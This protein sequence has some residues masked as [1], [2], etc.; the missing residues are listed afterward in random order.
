LADL[1]VFPHCDMH[2]ALH[3]APN[4]RIRVF[5]RSPAA[6]N[7]TYT[8]TDVTSQCTF[9]FFAPYNAVGSRLQAFVAIDP[10]TGAVTANAV[11]INLIQIRLN[12]QYIVARI[13][14]HDTILGWWFGNGSITT[15]LD[16]R[17]AHAQPSIYALFSDDGAVGTD[18]VGDISGHGYVALTSGNPAVFTVDGNGRLQ[19]VSETDPHQP[20]PKLTG[21]FLA[22]D[23]TIDVRVVDYGKAR[24]I[25]DAVRVY[26][27]AGA[28]EAH[29]IVFIAEGFRDSGDDRARFD[30]IVERVVDEIFSKPRHAPYTFLQGSF[31]IWKAYEPSQQHAMTCGY[32]IN[33]EDTGSL[34]KGYPIPYNKQLGSDGSQYTLELLVSKVGLPLRNESRNASDLRNLW[35]SQSLTN[36]NSNQVND[37]LITAWKG[38]KSLGILEARDTAFG[39]Y[40]GSRY[41]DRS[42]GSGKVEPPATDGPADPKL[43]PFVARVY[44]WFTFMPRRLLIPDPRRHPPELHQ[45]NATNAGNSILQY[46]SSLR[47]RFWG[48]PNIG[49]EWLP[50]PAKFKRSRGLV[51]IVANEG[52]HGGGN[53]ND[54]TMT[55]VTSA[56]LNNIGFQYSSTAT[57]KIMR[58][59]PPDPIRL[60]VDHIVNTATHELGHSFNLG[61][62]YESFPGDDP[63][64]KFA[65]DL[66]SDNLSRLGAVFLHGAT[67]PDGT[68][69]FAD[70]QIDPD[71]VKWF[72]LL[73]MQVSDVLIKDSETQGSNIKVTIDKRFI[74]GWAAAKSKSWPAHLRRRD[75]TGGPDATITA[76]GRQLPLKVGSNQ[77][78]VGLDIG[79]IDENQGTILL[80]GGG[81]PPAPFPV[82]PKGSF[83]FVPSRDS[84]GDLMFVVEKKVLEWLKQNHLVLNK[85]TDTSKVNA[86]EDNPIDISD[87]H[88]PCKSYKVIG[89]YEGASYYTAEDYRPA[90]LCKMRKQ[91]DAGTGDGEFCH[92]CKYLIVQRVDPKLLALLDANYYPTAKKEK[93]NA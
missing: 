79:D 81:L 65:S 53:F 69:L 49:Q 41:A 17:F 93:K 25:L 51:V 43:Q 12:D 3:G 21:S 64:A 5:S 16:N 71:K 72:K 14:V 55:S 36:F 7:R 37:A 15:A 13:Q 29:N 62:E 46:L 35:N 26:D 32:G 87:F 76:E 78:L 63:N 45:S 42:S 92:V 11:G 1:V 22:V 38:Q 31:N 2:V 58:R 10:A 59:V 77:Y 83:I 27:I 90:G 70:H 82:F 66:D 28:A 85:D 19:G 61:D 80:G 91:S 57:E 23:H 88:A 67:Q 86:E 34:P 9:D 74:A 40:L 8:L 24:P 6:D 30:E 73:R 52:I 54:S 89:I 50:E 18:L 44:E 60:D 56:E 39:L 47:G 20:P 4:L 33:D 84:G 75:F 68:V 48:N